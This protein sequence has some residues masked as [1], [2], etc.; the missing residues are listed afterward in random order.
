MNWDNGQG[1]REVDSL[2]VTLQI[3]DPTIHQ[4]IL[5]K[6]T[7]PKVIITNITAKFTNTRKRFAL[8]KTTF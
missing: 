3:S 1:W 7:D 5:K 8:D 2:L 4:M 6:M